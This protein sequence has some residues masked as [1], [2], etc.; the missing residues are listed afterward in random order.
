MSRSWLADAKVIQDLGNH[1]YVPRHFKDWDD[2][3]DARAERNAKIR[4]SQPLPVE[5]QY[6]PFFGSRMHD[7]R[8]IAVERTPSLIRVRLDDIN[9]EDFARALAHVLE[10]ERPVSRWPVDLLFH[11]PVYM[12]AAH[13]DPESKLRFADIDKIHSDEPQS[14]DE[15]LYDWFFQQDGRIQWIA[16]IWLHPR[17][18]ERLS[19]AVYLMIDCEKATAEDHRAAAL[20]KSFGPAV[21]S[22]WSD[23]LSGTDV[24]DSPHGL[25]IWDDMIAFIRR[26]LAHYQFTKSDFRSVGF[27]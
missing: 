22:I 10:I 21:R 1:F 13:Y 3:R 9:T 6:V 7:S 11:K 16:E 23:Y 25:A 8:V 5:P 2:E 4:F 12:R 20:E 24:G 27:P 19:Q 17:R 15:F 18:S 14:G 26:R